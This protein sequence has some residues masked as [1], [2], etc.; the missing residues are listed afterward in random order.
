MLKHVRKQ[1]PWCSKESWQLG[2]NAFQLGLG[3]V[4]VDD[5]VGPEVCAGNARDPLSRFEPL[6]YG[7]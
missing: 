2:Q 4:Q 3:G 6:R 5:V 1:R 7:G